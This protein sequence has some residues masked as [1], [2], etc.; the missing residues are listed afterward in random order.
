MGQA[1]IYGRWQW[2]LD[3]GAH[4]P[5]I[6]VAY[7]A[8]AAIGQDYSALTARSAQQE[9]ALRLDRNL[10][11]VC[12]SP[13]ARSGSTAS[14]GRAGRRV[15]IVDTA[16]LVRAPMLLKE[17]YK[18][19]DAPAEAI[20][21]DF[22]VATFRKGLTPGIFGTEGQLMKI[23]RRAKGR[24]ASPTARCMRRII[25][26]TSSSSSERSRKRW[27]SRQREWSARSST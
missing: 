4:P 19:P 22:F 7:T 16:K 15:R 9:A 23:I 2:C 1:I 13:M 25:S 18:R 5:R 10:R 17:Y 14:A 8:G 20:D 12:L 27:C 6:R 3:A 26:R 21:G 11:Y 24:G